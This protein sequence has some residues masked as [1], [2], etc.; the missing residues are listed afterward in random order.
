MDL[1][2]LKYRKEKGE[3]K[4]LPFFCL[5]FCKMT[6]CKNEILNVDISDKNSQN[7]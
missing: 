7:F 2:V 3:G 4:T 6:L 5:D 1:F